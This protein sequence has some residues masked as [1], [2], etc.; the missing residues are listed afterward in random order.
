LWA[1]LGI[2]AHFAGQYNE[3]VHAFER[4]LSMEPDYF[5]RRPDDRKLL[6]ASRQKR[7]YRP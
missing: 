1:S 3:S 5:E 6:E 7:P 2:W 4:A